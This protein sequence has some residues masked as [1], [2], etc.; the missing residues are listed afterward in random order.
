[1]AGRDSALAS[2]GT[3]GRTDRP[4]LAAVNVGDR[5]KGRLRFP[6]V[7]DVPAEAGAVAEALRSALSPGFRVQQ[8]GQDTLGDGHAAERIRS[9]LEAWRPP[10]PP[11]KR[12][13]C[14]PP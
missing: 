11:I 10:R 2:L 7:I 1:M 3:M 9:V 13:S 12:A 5:Q 4:G 8:A 14:G 6:S